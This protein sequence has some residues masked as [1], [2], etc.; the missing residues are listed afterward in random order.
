MKVKLQFMDDFGHV[1]DD[2]IVNTSDL[3]EVQNELPRLIGKDL[4]T[5][6]KYWDEFKKDYV[7]WWYKK[8]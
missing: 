1:V 4:V 5:G 3:H 7:M 8:K 2:V 6:Y